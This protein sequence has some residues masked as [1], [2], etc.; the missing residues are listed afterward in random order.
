[1]GFD[2]V[3]DGC[4]CTSDPETSRQVRIILQNYISVD[5]GSY[6]STFKIS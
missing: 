1:M 4:F 3:F 5:C 2:F 6:V